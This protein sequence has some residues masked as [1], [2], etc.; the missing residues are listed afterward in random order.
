MSI[1][2]VWMKMWCIL[3]NGN[4]N[5]NGSWFV[6]SIEIF[7]FCCRQKFPVLFSIRYSFSSVFVCTILK[8]FLSFMLSILIEIDNRFHSNYNFEST[9]KWFIFCFVCCQFRKW[10]WQTLWQHDTFIKLTFFSCLISISTHSMRFH[11]QRIS[12]CRCQY[13]KC[14]PWQKEDFDNFCCFFSSF[15]IETVNFTIVIVQSSFKRYKL[16]DWSSRWNS[17]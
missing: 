1:E 2:C 15:A 13:Q 5:C 14:W 12:A 16:S 10:Q 7:F 17:T 8:W 6:V 11:H 9:R 4:C 3:Q